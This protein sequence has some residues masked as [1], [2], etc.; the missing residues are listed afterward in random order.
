MT[1]EVERNC[2]TPSD[3]PSAPDLEVLICTHNRSALLKHALDS[4]NRCVIP[5]NARIG[6][7]VVA[8]A[9]SDDTAMVLANHSSGNAK[10]PLRWIEEPRAGKSHA[11]NTALSRARGSVIALVDDDHRVDHGYLQAI[12]NGSRAHPEMDLFCGRI[13]PDWNGE[14]PPW[15]HDTGP[16]R[17]YPLPVPRFELGDHEMVVDTQK[18]IPGGGNLAIRRTLFRTA[19][20]FR[21]ELGPKGHNLAGSEDIEWIRRA[22]SKGARLYYLPDMI[23]YHYVDL[24]RL[25]TRYIMRKAYHRSASTF[26]ATTATSGPLGVPPYML[27]KALTYLGNAMVSFNRDRRRFYLTRLAAALGE[28]KGARQQRHQGRSSLPSRH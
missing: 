26:H 14:E 8:N 12:I 3:Y 13:L 27:R 21:T 25:T 2:F 18:A 11:L 28:I 15:V 20:P 10:L 16:Y 7:F 9:C 5:N 24:E 19:G 17:I 23:Q 4:L 1:E 22:T 6:I